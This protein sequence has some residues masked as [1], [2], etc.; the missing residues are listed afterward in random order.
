MGTLVIGVADTWTTERPW[1][2]AAKAL[3]HQSS[4]WRPPTYIG[5]QAP[6][7]PPPD[8]STPKA[9]ND[10]IREFCGKPWLSTSDKAFAKAYKEFR[11]VTPAMRCA[12][13]DWH[14]SKWE[15]IRKD[16]ELTLAPAPEP[17]PMPA[18]SKAYRPAVH[19]T[20]RAGPPLDKP[21]R[22]G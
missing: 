16:G 10:R 1:D 5:F 22:I 3:K 9:V 14:T 19:W 8:Y 18:I 6:V 12:I 13:E 21:K 17:R 2:P 7:P 4:C 20:R 11:K 15:V